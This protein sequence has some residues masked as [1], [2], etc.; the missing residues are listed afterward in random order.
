MRREMEKGTQVGRKISEFV[1]RGE[2]VYDEIIQTI[3][4]N[5]LREADCAAGFILDGFPRSLNQAEFL[6]D[7]LKRM[8]V[9]VDVVLNI[10][11][12]DQTVV[13]RLTRRNR[14]DDMPETIR[15]RLRIYRKVSAPLVAYYDREGLV[16]KIDGDGSLEEV[17]QRILKCL[18]KAN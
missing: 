12:P 7:V 8:E 9:P 17:T 11:V 14:E 10:Q 5:R 2:L 15:H 16:R 1:N 3:L 18:A 13:R 6:N 4:E